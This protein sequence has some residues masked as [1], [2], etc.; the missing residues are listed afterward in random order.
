M[1][2]TLIFIILLSLLMAVLCSC[3]ITAD[4]GDDT[5]SQES[6]GNAIASNNSSASTLGNYEVVID[7]CRI[8][9]DYQ[10]N[11]IAIV[12]Y[13]FTNNDDDAAAFSW[14]IETNVYQDGIGL[15]KCYFADDSANYSSDNQSKEIKTGASLFVEV[16]YELNDA[17]TDIEVEV[18]ELISF[19]NKKITKVFSIT[20]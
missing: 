4:L 13:K 7:S 11:P 18:S 2:K 16:A 5:N 1:K 12:K 9:E 17:T 20:Q 14:T 10:G 19:N 6:N 8:A 15:N 3:V